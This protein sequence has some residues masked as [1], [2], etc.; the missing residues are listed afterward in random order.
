MALL[1]LGGNLV[2]T[3]RADMRTA[4]GS[5]ASLETLCTVGVLAVPALGDRSTPWGSLAGSLAESERDPASDNT[6]ESLVGGARHLS[7]VYTCTHAQH[8]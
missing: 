2:V 8:A 6:V 5:P 3:S 7:V 4:C 1:V